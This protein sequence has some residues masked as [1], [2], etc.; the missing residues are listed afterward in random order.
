MKLLM[1]ILRQVILSE[2]AQIIIRET[3]KIAAEII[4][5]AILKML[6]TN[7]TRKIEGERD[8]Q[9][10]DQSVSSSKSEKQ[11][12]GLRIVAD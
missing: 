12:C 7:T 11:N 5:E 3:Y 8:V 10:R 9:L 2:A 1:G 6:Q 4:S